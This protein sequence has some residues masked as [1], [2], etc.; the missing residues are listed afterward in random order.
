M[1][2]TIILFDIDNTIYKCTKIIILNL[3]KNNVY[4]KKCDTRTLK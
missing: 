2:N 3:N 1:H 4:N